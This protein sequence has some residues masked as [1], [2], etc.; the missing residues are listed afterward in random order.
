MSAKNII[1]K[2]SPHTIK[3]FELIEE[4]I[5]SWAQKLM[6]NDYCNGLIFIDCMCN[7]G[8]Y[9]G[10][11]GQFVKGTAVRVS[12]ELL[13]VARTYPNKRVFIHLNDKD[14]KRVDE[15]ELHLPHNEGNF[16]I[17]T[18]RSDA[19][20]FLKTIGEQ[21]YQ[22]RRMHLHYFLLYD[23][24]DASIDWEALEPFFLNWGEVLINHMVSDP[25]RAIKTVKRKATMEKYEKT[26]REDF[27]ELLHYGNDKDALDARVKK[28]IAAYHGPGRYYVATFPF[29]NSNNSRLYSLLHC[30][31]H[32]D[33]FKLFKSC[34]WKVFGAQSSNK[35]GSNRGQMSFDF[36]GNASIDSDETCYNVR[37][38]AKYLQNKFKGQE[39]VPLSDLWEL[40][41]EHPIF[42][43]E[44]FR[45]EIKRELVSLYGAKIKR[46]EQVGMTKKEVITF[47]HKEGL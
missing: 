35:H 20:E 31:N 22:I 1:S 3:K 13:K 17:A 9:T 36:D 23:P 44:N 39:Q 27:K 40:L 5:K 10:N 28:I 8:I 21:L 24:Y 6:L 18:S 14:V 4:Y 25:A 45:T 7:S 34:A 41:D 19:S 43:S 37:D 15:L 26:Y 47:S 46:I 32:K 12:E 29:Y 16:T 42:P 33:G 2:A 30:T 38:I 11:A